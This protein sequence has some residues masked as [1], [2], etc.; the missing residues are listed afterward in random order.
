MQ[1]YTAL[2]HMIKKNDQIHDLIEL[3]IFICHAMLR[4]ESPKYNFLYLIVP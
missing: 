3:P 2:D 1:E 4:I